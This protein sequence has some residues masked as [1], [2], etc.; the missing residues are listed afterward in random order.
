MTIGQLELSERCAGSHEKTVWW[1]N[2][3]VGFIAGIINI[4]LAWL[5]RRLR[6]VDIY[7]LPLF[8]RVL[9]KVGVFPIL[10]HFI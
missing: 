9:N 3:D 2:A 6:S 4:S 5:M 8:G 1:C 10:V 7:K